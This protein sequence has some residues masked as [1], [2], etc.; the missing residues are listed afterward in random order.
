MFMP[1]QSAL[2]KLAESK[3]ILPRKYN[4]QRKLQPDTVLQHFTT[5]FRVYPVVHPVCVK[6]WDAEKM[7]S[8]LKLHEYDELLERAQTLTEKGNSTHA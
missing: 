7:H 4:E 8:V 3:K 1:D 2:N 6:P 5:S